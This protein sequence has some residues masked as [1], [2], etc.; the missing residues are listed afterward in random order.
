MQATSRCLVGI[1]LLC[2]ASSVT[3]IEF[4][5]GLDPSQAVPPPALNGASP[6]GSATVDV[7]TITGDVSVAG[8]FAGLSSPATAAHLHGLAP[9]GSAAGVIFGFTVDADTS[10][11]FTGS[12][13]LAP[14]DVDGLLDRL[15]Y[16]NLHTSMNPPGE[17]R[18]QVVDDDIL[19]FRLPLEP[20]QAVPLPT[21][22]GASPTGMARV[23]VDKSSGDVEVVGTY[24]GMTSDVTAAHLHGLAP[25]GAAAGVIF[26]FSV[27]GGTD[28]TFSGAGMLT[29]DDLSG[30][31][32]GETYVNIHTSGNPP[33]EIRA[34]V[35]EP[36][37][38]FLLLLGLVGFLRRRPRR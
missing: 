8:D 1:A 13:T 14:A 17:I 23:V 11:S 3:A 25:A 18:G 22:D 24:S 19:V 38:A 32:S 16:V 35:P 21:L 34:Q 36:S 20:G 31:L 6:S 33:G 7:N 10:G 37:S 9:A 4:N 28:G 2:C 12:G 30:L 29:P 26:G 27:S 15:T 5:V